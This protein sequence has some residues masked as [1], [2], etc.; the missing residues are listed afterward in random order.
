MPSKLLQLENRHLGAMIADLILIVSGALSFGEQE[1]FSGIQELSSATI[2]MMFIV[3]I[4]IIPWYMGYLLQVFESYTKIFQQIA[5]WFFGIITLALVVFLIV[6]FLPMMEEKTSLTPAE[7]FL[8]AFGLFFLV[9]GPMMIIGGYVDGKSIDSSRDKKNP[10][11]RPMYT[12]VMGII[13]LSILYLILIVGWFDP[14]WEGNSNFLVILLAFLVGPIGALITFIPVVFFGKW[15]EKVDTLRILPHLTYI[16][17]PVITFNTLIWWNDIVLYNLWGGSQPSVSQIIWSMVLAGIIPFR[18]LMLFKP[19]F[20]WTG[21]IFGLIA[22][23]VYIAGVL[24][25]QGAIS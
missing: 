7:N 15:L 12:T 4:T 11:L 9:L 5:K 20:K 2:V 17:L 16:A 10:Y 18:L 6:T 24:Y 21:I 23:G 22:L 3:V 8:F 19:P 1:K 25:Q 14:N 13:T